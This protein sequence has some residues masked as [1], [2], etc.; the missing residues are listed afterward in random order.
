MVV[1]PL[2][3]DNGLENN[4]KHGHVEEMLI[5]EIKDVMK[6]YKNGHVERAPVA[7]SVTPFLA[8]D[9]NVTARDVYIDRGTNVW[10]RTYVPQCD[11]YDSKFPLLVYFH[12][13]GFCIG[14]TAWK[15]YH[16]FLG[17]LS[18]ESQCIIV[19][20]NYRLAPENRLPAAYE[21][22]IKALK[23]VKQQENGPSSE[24]W[25][26]YCD[27][28]S[29]FIGGDSAGANIAYNVALKLG[30]EQTIRPIDIK[31]IVMVQP[32]FGGE[33][34]TDSEINGSKSGKL[35]LNVG[36][37]DTYWRLALPQGVN[38]DHPWCNPLVEGIRTMEN[39]K[40]MVCVA[41]EDMLRDRTMEFCLVLSKAG[42]EV[43]R[44]VCEDVGHAFHIVDM[45]H[46]S[47]IR[48]REMISEIVAFITEIKNLT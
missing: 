7:Q 17:S 26:K 23:W 34:R 16:E 28:T 13:G 27:F 18:S 35:K 15:H 2:G 12:G 47:Q 6:V 3:R 5:E 44:I 25:T 8:P 33:K 10:A 9:L 42:N 30:T 21:D 40:V 39:M 36:V 37:S 4:S 38:R 19:S 20:V 14:S 24:Y 1:V 46:V 32:F 45:S 43:K 22:G 41:G 11:M 31:G 48:K 29:I